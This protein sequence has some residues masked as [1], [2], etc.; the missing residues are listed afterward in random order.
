MNEALPW[1]HNM[2]KKRFITIKN[3][4]DEKKEYLNLSL[5][6]GKSGLNNRI[7]NSRIQ[8][9]GLAFAGYMDKIDPERVQVLGSTE[10]EYLTEHI[11]EKRQL[12]ILTSWTSRPLCCI[13]VTKGLDPPMALKEISN[14]KGIPLLKSNLQSSVLISRL[15]SFLEEELAEET[16]A[17]GTFVDIFGVGVLI[18]GRSGIGKSECALELVSRGH[19]LISDDNVKIRHIPPDILIGT[20]YDIT[21][22]KIE[23]RGVGII[24]VKK[25]FGVASVIEKKR[26]EL[27]IMLVD[28]KEEEYDRLGMESQN[29]EFLGVKIPLYRM[30]VA[31]GRNLAIILEVA[32]RNYLLKTEGIDSTMELDE[33]LKKR[34]MPKK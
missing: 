2:V 22:Y 11:D 30:P 27:A 21:K 26:M 25:I 12:E 18:L 7:E 20:G 6:A 10:L 3:F 34:Y 16:N 24:D 15:T 28:W 17:H 9:P 29:T 23:I 31:P 13:L 5:I 19:Q 4:F 8:R 33:R 1:E 14:K 32:V